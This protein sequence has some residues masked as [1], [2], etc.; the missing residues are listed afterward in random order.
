MP[1]VNIN[2][3]VTKPTETLSNNY[4]LVIG[5][6]DRV[7]VCTN[8]SGTLVITVPTDTVTFPIG[9]QV[10]FIRQGTNQVAGKVQIV[11][12]SGVTL[13]SANTNRF[14]KNVNGTAALIKT[15]ANT[16]TLAGSLEAS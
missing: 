9:S 10:A 14:I 11:P 15:A 4:T 5:D 6:K 8:A 12:A 16:W 7:K 2:K 1:I 13:N 3:P